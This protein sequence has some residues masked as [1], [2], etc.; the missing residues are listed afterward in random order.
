MTVSG[1][2]PLQYFLTFVYST[3]NTYF[4][5]LMLSQ[6]VVVFRCKVEKYIMTNLGIKNILWD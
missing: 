4:F 1:K 5:I 2:G 6:N 3:V